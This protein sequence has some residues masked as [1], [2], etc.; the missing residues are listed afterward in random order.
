MQRKVIVVTGG[1]S[2]I[3]LAAAKELA[4]KG[5]RVFVAGRRAS[6]DVAVIEMEGGGTLENLPLDVSKNESI[7]QALRIVTEKTGGYG[8]DILVNNAGYATAGPILELSEESL[9]AQF[10]TNVFGLIAVTKRFAEA[11][12]D[13]K[14]GR[15]V[16]VGSVSGRIPAPMLG[17][18][19]ATKYALEALNDAMRMEL[20]A[21][22]IDVAL[23]DPGTIKTEFAGVTIAQAVAHQ[24]RGTRYGAAFANINALETKFGALAASTKHTS[25]AILH[26][27]LAERP[28]TRYVAPRRFWLAIVLF[29]IVPAR[30]YDFVARSAFG[31]TRKKLLGNS[32]L[33]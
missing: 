15:I 7:D 10:E 14:K 13:R 8:I 23:V 22:G 27:A 16:N 2:G 24:E 21:F 30:I 9:R 33:T 12:I 28:C 17:A 29:T 3:G 11:M 1:T 6:A 32:S 4:A 25:R 19:H 5:H 26:A 18:Y 20:A 31:L